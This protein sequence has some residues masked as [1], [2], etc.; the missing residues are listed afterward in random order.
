MNRACTIL[1]VF[2]IWMVTFSLLIIVP[3]NHTRQIQHKT[4]PTQTQFHYNSEKKQEYQHPFDALNI[5]KV[6]YRTNKSKSI[7]KRMKTL[8]HDKWIQ[9]N[10]EFT[11]IWYD[12]QEADQFMSTQ[13]TRIQNAYNTL[14]PGAYKADLWRLC[15]LYTHGGM[16]VDSFS[17]PFTPI[18]TW[19]TRDD[20]AVAKGQ[21]YSFIS[22]RDMQ[23]EA[24]HQGLIIASK[25]HP[26]LKRAI[27][28]ICRNVEQKYYGENSLHV[29]GPV[30]MYKSIEDEL[31]HRNISVEYVPVIYTKHSRK[32]LG[33]NFK[34]GWNIDY[35]V[36]EASGKPN[37]QLL[38]FYLFD[39]QG[40]QRQVVVSHNKVIMKKKF[41]SLLELYRKRMKSNSYPTLWKNKQIYKVK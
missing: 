25:H 12:N 14:V 29:T 37:T 7:S 15:I 41:S 16:Y 38:P 21:K 8:C 1:A 33:P 23:K 17:V 31:R 20:V 39:F 6:I 19:V 27:D 34:L 28:N 22:V 13:T 2:V 11:M 10:P 32:D 4:S 36:D 9:L 30:C 5:P 26:F 40:P 35:P 24:I 3:L 18:K